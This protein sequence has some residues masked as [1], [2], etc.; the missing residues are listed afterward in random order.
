MRP[1]HI[2]LIAKR[3][4]IQLKQ[5]PRYIILSIMAPL[6]I[7]FLLQVFIDTMPSTFPTERFVIPIS[8]FVVHFLSFILNM[9]FLVQERKNGTLERMFMNGVTQIEVI[10]GYV[11]G[12]LGLSTLQ[13]VIVLTEVI[14]LFDLSYSSEQLLLMFFVTWLLSVAS[15]ALGLFFSTF[16]RHE[17]HIIPFI[18]L[19]EFPSVFLSGLLIDFEKLPTWGQMI[20]QITPLYYTN[21]ILLELI[22]DTYI[23]EDLLPDILIL[24]LFVVGLLVLSSITLRNSTNQ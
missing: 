7:I 20:G 6:V 16:A 12:Y 9:I 11:L 1:G 5:D 17:G 10:G 18:P 24:V 4:L 22:S 21:N 13:T 2:A 19:V 14:F 8:A 23:I 15:V 3:T